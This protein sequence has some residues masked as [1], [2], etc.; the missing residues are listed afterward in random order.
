[1][2]AI[3]HFFFKLSFEFCSLQKSLKMKIILDSFLPVAGWSF[4]SYVS[5]PLIIR[6]TPHITEID[7]I[8][9]EQ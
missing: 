1:M 3:E 9:R 8:D 2:H 7:F 5:Q 4:Y 6:P